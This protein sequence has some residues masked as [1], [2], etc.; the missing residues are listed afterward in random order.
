MR[1]DHTKMAL[2][3]KILRN[4]NSQTRFCCLYVNPLSNF[5]GKQAVA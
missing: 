1:S 3:E 4:K 5:E 2:R